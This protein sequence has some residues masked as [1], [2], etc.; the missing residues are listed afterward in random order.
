[1]NGATRSR[2]AGSHVIR[3]GW[4][5]ACWLHL[6]NFPGFSPS[7][8][9]FSAAQDSKTA[10]LLSK[11]FNTTGLAD[12]RSATRIT[13][14]KHPQGMPYL[15]KL[16]SG[17]CSLRHTRPGAPVFPC[18]PTASR[19]SQQ[20][21]ARHTLHRRRHPV[22]RIGYLHSR[23]QDHRG[24]SSA[25]PCPCRPILVEAFARRNGVEGHISVTSAPLHAAPARLDARGFR[26]LTRL[27]I[28][29]IEPSGP[30]VSCCA[31]VAT[32]HGL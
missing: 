27:A 22:G 13:L 18:T 25:R 28:G 8:G 2:F 9:R 31:G 21:T 12:L 23:R 6:S 19:Q 26:S 3:R 4:C 32:P 7:P 14:R 10:C 17:A 5:L 15:L 16:S 1:M 20:P 11:D 24:I 30:E 29:C